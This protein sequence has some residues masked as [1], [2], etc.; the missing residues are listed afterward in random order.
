MVHLLE[1]AVLGPQVLQLAGGVVSLQHLDSN[2]RVPS[3]HKI[4]GFTRH[5]PAKLSLTKSLFQNQL[6]SGK[7]IYVQI[8]YVLRKYGEIQ[9]RMLLL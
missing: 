5:N 1:Q 3:T 7:F 2:P 9:C 4:Q 8:S 6:F